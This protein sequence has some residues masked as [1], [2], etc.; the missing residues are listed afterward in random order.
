LGSVFTI[1]LRKGFEHIKDSDTVL[2]SS[3]RPAQKTKITETVHHPKL[4]RNGHGRERAAILIVE[5][6]DDFRSYLQSV[7]SDTY[8]VATAR[9][10]NEALEML[11]TT[12]PDLI[13]SDVMMP[14]MDGFQFVQN[15][16]EI[17]QFRHL[18]VLFLSAKDLDKDKEQGLSTGADVYLT[19]PVKSKLLR[20]QI[21]ALLRR[22]RLIQGNQLHNASDDEDELVTDVREIVYRHLANPDLTVEMLADFLYVSR[23]KLYADW[24]EV[25]DTSLNAF[26]KEIRL[27]EAKKLIT[28]HDFSVQETAAAVGFPDPNYFSTSFK[29]EFGVSPSQAKS[30]M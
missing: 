30:N 1:T 15:I 11:K 13:L 8:E 26:I 12:N 6:N 28:E 18:P 5:D 3:H 2:H 19:K 24:K 21:A 27:D 20:S 16:R 10:G 7:L 14:G 9:E 4:N 29:K 22:E 17:E 25:C 23:S